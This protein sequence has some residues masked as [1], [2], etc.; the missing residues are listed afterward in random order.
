MA[1]F[2]DLLTRAATEVA[3]HKEW[4]VISFMLLLLLYQLVTSRHDRNKR[5]QEELEKDKTMA[6][7]LDHRHEKY[8][9]VFER[10]TTIVAEARVAI[11]CMATRVED[12]EDRIDTMDK[13]CDARQ[14]KRKRSRATDRTT[15]EDST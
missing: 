2:I 8:E 15:R 5:R 3:K 14:L 10:S 1:E 7:L 11:D 13:R 12:L 6:D 4:G 9:D